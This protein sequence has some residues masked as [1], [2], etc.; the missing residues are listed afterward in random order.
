VRS[1]FVNCGQFYD[2]WLKKKRKRNI[3]ISTQ[4]RTFNS[5][6]I[7]GE[8][9][10]VFK[11]KLSLKWF[12][13]RPSPFRTGTQMARSVTTISCLTVAVVYHP[14]DITYFVNFSPCECAIQQSLRKSV[15]RSRSG[16][17]FWWCSLRIWPDEHLFW[18]VLCFW[19]YFQAHVRKI[20]PIVH[21]RFLSGYYSYLP[22][23]LP[24]VPHSPIFWLCNRVTH[25]P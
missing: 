15:Q 3:K 24:S 25:R 13:S 20:S 12:R 6:Q 22:V 8:G 2:V 10:T 17:V 1:D 7:Y 19:Q 14:A 5:R 21:D 11:H 9:N 18:R 23:T 16:L 4:R